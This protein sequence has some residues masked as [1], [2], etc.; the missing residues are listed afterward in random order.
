M[1]GRIERHDRARNDLDEIA[2]YI[3]QR[4]PR[5]ALRFID[6]AKAT[7]ERLVGMPGMG[8]RYESED[9]VTADELRYFPISQ[10]PTYLVFYRPLPEGIAVVRVLHGARDIG[11]ILAEDFGIPE[12]V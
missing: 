12:E 7:F 4:N 5:A 10:F 9:P 2:E 11:G 1:T 6:A 8:T 3:R